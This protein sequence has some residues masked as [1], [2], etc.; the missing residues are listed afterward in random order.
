MVTNS[1]WLSDDYG[2]I[3]IMNGITMDYEWDYEWDCYG[4][5]NGLIMG[6]LWDYEWDYYGII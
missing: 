2:T 4:I 1:W 3:R 6:L 5:M